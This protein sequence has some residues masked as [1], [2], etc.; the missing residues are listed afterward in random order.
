MLMDTPEP[1]AKRKLL[2]HTLK[3]ILIAVAVGAIVL[4][5][6]LSYVNRRETDRI[7]GKHA[8]S[9]ANGEYLGIIKG[10]GRSSKSGNRVIFI[11][12]PTGALIELDGSYVDIR[13]NPPERE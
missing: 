11:S 10:R 4:A 5:I 8:F 1:S 7:V 12:Q 3:Q 13:D 6:Y 2:R 9:T